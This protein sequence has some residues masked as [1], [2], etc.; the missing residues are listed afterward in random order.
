LNKRIHLLPALFLIWANTHAG[1]FLG[2]LI[3]GIYTAGIFYKWIL[4]KTDL[5]ELRSFILIIITATIATL[6]NPF[7][8]K[9]YLGIYNHM[10]I[11]MNTLIAEWVPPPQNYVL[12][13]LTIS[14]LLIY[15]H[16]SKTKIKDFNV[17]F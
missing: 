14:G 2:P 6:I 17:F 5:H 7:G 1:F 13:I 12:L 16:L 10:Q 11:P 8:Y 4:K 3:L 9:L 15:K